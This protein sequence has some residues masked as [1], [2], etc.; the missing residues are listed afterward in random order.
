MKKHLL[1][2]FLLTLTAAMA[3]AQPK[4]SVGI[5]RTRL[6]MTDGTSIVIPDSS[7][8]RITYTPKDAKDFSQGFMMNIQKRVAGRDTTLVI[9]ADEVTDIDYAEM[10]YYE[11]FAGDW[12]LVGSP[13][14]GELA[15]LVDYGGRLNP[16][17]KSSANSIRLDAKLPP[18]DSPDY[19]NKIY[20]HADSFVV[21]NLRTEVDADG[22]VLRREQL[23]IPVD[24]D[25]NFYYD[26]VADTGHVEM[27]LD[28]SREAST[29]KV[30][31]DEH[32]YITD[33][34]NNNFYYSYWLDDAMKERTRLGL[35]PDT[36]ERHLVLL[37]EIIEKDEQGRQY[38]LA[39]MNLRSCWKPDDMKNA[40]FQHKFPKVYHIYVVNSMELPYDYFRSA[41][42]GYLEIQVSNR[43][44][45]EPWTKPL[46]EE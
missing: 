14:G 31:D 42:V 30:G 5:Y 1:L 20:M 43:L 24:F 41:D 10:T 15:D 35:T 2:T 37:T 8:T 11:Q 6:T 9:P 36:G 40:K 18:V 21:R 22:N 39:G 25:L 38:Y 32:Y 13:D 34:K 44:M 4:G 33:F 45:R 26:E 28:A 3:M 27:V 19:G 16:I 46:I 12:F 17:W 7:L 23:V 29:L